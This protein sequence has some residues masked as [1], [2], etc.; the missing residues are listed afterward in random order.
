[1]DITPH[2]K[3]M[4]EGFVNSNG[5][6]I[7]LE[8]AFKKADHPFR[9]AIVCAMWLTGFDVPSLSTLYLDKP[10]KAHTLMQT[11]ARANRVSEGK[12]NG[13]I[14]DYCGIFKYLR[15]AL[16]T[17]TGQGD[18]G[19][20]FRGDKVDPTK[21]ATELIPELQE[22]IAF[23]RA[24]LEEG[25]ASLDDIIEKTGFERNAAIMAAKDV[26]NQNDETRKRLEIMCREAFKKF[27]ACLNDERVND[28]RRDYDAI[29]II[30]RSLEKDRQHADISDIIRQLHEIVDEAIVTAPAQVKEESTPYNI[31]NIDFDRLRKEFEKSP[32]KNTTVQNLKHA[33]EE[34]LARLLKQNPLRTNFQQH[35][36][37]IVEEYNREKD[38]ST[39][40]KT[41]EALLKFVQELGEEESR[42]VREGLD[43]ESLAIFDLLKKPDLNK[44]EIDRIKKVAVQLL[45][46]LKEGKLKTEHWK[47]KESTRDAVFT[48]IRDFL[49]DDT[50]GL[51]VDS[52]TEEE[53]TE[54]SHRV[55]Q[56]VFYAYPTVPSPIYAN[57]SYL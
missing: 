23:V 50:T 7:D 36:E 26:A 43:E 53:V 2:R 35:Y 54:I 41:F 47:E 42:A 20:D 13:M 22:A 57:V 27:K 17:Y 28:Y 18:S 9:V 24:F 56:H 52:Y 55:F 4:K 48:V 34:R 44:K 31:A 11:I 3:L 5:E 37:K 6:R 21:P 46:T 14:I 45:Q 25:G 38:R 15:Q 8:S 19:R 40:E 39:I 32:A 49:W 33:I 10:L 29:N 16:A 51:P 12:N 30:Y 1:M